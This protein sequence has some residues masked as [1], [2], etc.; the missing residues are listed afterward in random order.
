LFEERALSTLSG[1]K[2]EQLVDERILRLCL[3][4]QLVHLHFVFIIQCNINITYF[5]TLFGHN[6][7]CSSF[8]RAKPMF[9]D[10]EKKSFKPKTRKERGLEITFLEFAL[11]ARSSGESFLLPLQPI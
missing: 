8:D 7:S 3:V 9:L 10:I 1:T 6:K 11:L 4:D 5:P 2:Q